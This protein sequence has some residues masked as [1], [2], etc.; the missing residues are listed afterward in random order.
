MG[1]CQFDAIGSYR[2]INYDIPIVIMSNLYIC[3]ALPC[4]IM[5]LN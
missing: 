1:T 4:C 2:I 3:L 5:A